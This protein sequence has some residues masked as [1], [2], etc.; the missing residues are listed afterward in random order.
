MVAKHREDT[1]TLPPHNPQLWLEVGA[2]NGLDMNLIYNISMTTT[3]D[4]KVGCSVLTIDTSQSNL[5][6]P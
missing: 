5:N 2:T 1:S 4:M 6:R 3:R